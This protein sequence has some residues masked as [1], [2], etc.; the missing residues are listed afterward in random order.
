ME[1]TIKSVAIFGFGA[2]LLTRMGSFGSNRVYIYKNDHP[3]GVF[4][5]L[6]CSVALYKEAG[7]NDVKRVWS[8]RPIEFDQEPFKMRS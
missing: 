2:F 8:F 4:D 7:S 1:E 6:I 3:I 5:R